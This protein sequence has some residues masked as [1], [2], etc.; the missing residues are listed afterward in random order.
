MNRMGAIARRPWPGGIAWRWRGPPPCRTLIGL[1]QAAFDT[2]V[3]TAG[4]VTTMA[5]MFRQPEPGRRFPVSAPVDPW[6]GA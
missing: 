4:R 2:R 3:R 6:Q 5:W 1:R